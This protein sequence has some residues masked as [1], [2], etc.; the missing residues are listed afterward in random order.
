MDSADDFRHVGKA[1]GVQRVTQGPRV[2]HVAAAIHL[3]L[4]K[5]NADPSE[6]PLI[7][8]FATG[9]AYSPFSF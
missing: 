9:A 6:I 7:D 5:I 1:N 2:A 3:S 4:G 8:Y